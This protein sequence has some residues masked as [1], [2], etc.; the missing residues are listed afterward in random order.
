MM[1]GLLG[2]T[3][4]PIRL[5]DGSHRIF[6]GMSAPPIKGTQPEV[7][8]VERRKSQFGPKAVA[9]PGARLA[10][11]QALRVHGTMSASKI[12]PCPG[13]PPR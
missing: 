7:Y 10:G 3:T 1:V 5:A 6:D 2:G 11:A 12:T 9:A 4:C 8:D 13:V